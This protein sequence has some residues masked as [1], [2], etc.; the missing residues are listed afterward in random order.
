MPKP[1]DS[2]LDVIERMARERRDVQ[3]SLMDSHGRRSR[4]CP[5]CDIS[6]TPMRR[7]VKFCCREC[8]VNHERKRYSEIRR[9]R[10]KYDRL[11]D[12]LEA[13]GG[14]CLSAVASY[15]EVLYVALPKSSANLLVRDAQRTYEGLQRTHRY[16][17]ALRAGMRPRMEDEE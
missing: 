11:W 3:Y 12:E 14:E 10:S 9:A 5:D 8:R 15:L 4:K 17:T 2:A 6:F 13:K 16:I 1:E 7:N